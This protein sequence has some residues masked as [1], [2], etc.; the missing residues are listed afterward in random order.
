[1]GTSIAKRFSNICGA[2]ME[3]FFKLSKMQNENLR[4]TKAQVSKGYNSQV[5]WSVVQLTV[6]PFGV[7][8]GA[9]ACS[10]YLPGLFETTTRG[11][12]RNITDITN[13]KLHAIA[14]FLGKTDPDHIKSI[15][16]FANNLFNI[17]QKSKQGT[18]DKNT[19]ERQQ[20]TQ[21]ENSHLQ[22]LQTMLQTEKTLS[23]TERAMI[24]AF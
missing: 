1:M 8:A 17:P 4:H 18:I 23:E 14:T 22:T 6:A 9:N 3:T 13:P 2:N 5:F 11:W 20:T 24:S 19:Y 15:T 21:S 12:F 7:I 16:D 10:K